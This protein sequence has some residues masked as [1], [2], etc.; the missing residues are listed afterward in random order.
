MC[1][2][3]FVPAI[4][5]AIWVFFSK[6][7]WTWFRFIFVTILT[8]FLCLVVLACIL[9]LFEQ[10]NWPAPKI[11]FSEQSPSAW[12]LKVGNPITDKNGKP[13]GSQVILKNKDGKRVLW[14]EAWNSQDSFAS[15]AESSKKLIERRATQSG[16]K[17]KEDKFYFDEPKNKSASLI[18]RTQKND[19]MHNVVC[20]WWTQELEHEQ[21][22]LCS[23]ALGENVDISNDEEITDIISRTI[24]K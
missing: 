21:I 6:K 14:I 18:L 4:L 24:I 3:A 16:F 2:F 12:V 9:E 13:I 1:F 8:L 15:N 10:T 22:I 7:Q 23:A 11:A 5:T 20:R 19:I 17:I